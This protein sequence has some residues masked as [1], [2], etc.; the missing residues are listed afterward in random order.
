MTTTVRKYRLFIK[1]YRDYVNLSEFNENI[2][3]AYNEVNRHL[4]V[5]VYEKEY[6]VYGDLTANQAREAGR[7]IAKS[8]RELALLCV[9]KHGT[10][11]FIKFKEDKIER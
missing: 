6:H 5:E 10:H 8:C 11:L 4:R 1:E 3:F 2:R 7:L 9:H